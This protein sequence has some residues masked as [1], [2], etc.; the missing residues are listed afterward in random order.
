M[1]ETVYDLCAVSLACATDATIQPVGYNGFKASN[2]STVTARLG[3]KLNCSTNGYPPARITWSKDGSPPVA[4]NEI[5]VD[6]LGEHTVICY[7]APDTTLCT[8]TVSVVIKVNVIGTSPPVFDL[9]RS[10]ATA[11]F[12]QSLASLSG[13]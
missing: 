1:T 6:K 12:C 5:V 13:W 2:G 4:G 3:D 8:G 9:C 10:V 7:A 11:V